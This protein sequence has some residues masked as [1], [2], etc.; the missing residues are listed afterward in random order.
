MKRMYLK[1]GFPLAL[2]LVAGVVSAQEMPRQM[3]IGAEPAVQP[4]VALEVSGLDAYEQMLLDADQLVRNG[5]PAEAYALLEPLEFEHAGEVRFDYLIGIAALDSGQPD[6]ATLAFER[7]LAVDSSFAGARL[8]MARAYYQ[9]GDLLRAKVEFDAVLK[10]DPPEAAR[11]TIEKY[12]AAIDAKLHAMDT[13]VT[14]YVEGTVGYDTNVNNATGQAQISVPALGNLVFTL[15]PSNQK[16]ADSYFGLNAGVSVAHPVN[17][18]VALYAGADIRDRSNSTL[19]SF[20]SVSLDGRAGG[21]FTLSKEDSLRVGLMAGQYTLNNLRNRDTLG[22]NGE[23]S[24]VFS[25]TNQMSL[26]FQQMAY[27][28]VDP[29]MRQEDF[30][31]GVLGAGWRHVRPDGKSVVFGSLFYGEERDNPAAGRT[32]GAKNFIGLKAGGQFALLDD[33]ELFLSAGAVDGKYSK[34]NL[35]FQV[36]RN[37]VLND[38]TA[39]VNWHLDKLWTVRPQLSWTHNQSNISLYSYDRIDGSVTVRRDFD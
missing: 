32:D 34:V 36:N 24:H 39:G 31:Q 8:D 25:P 11:S 37:D 9:L 12:L 21:V 28:F 27:R 35:L 1:G 2:L 6:K 22:V 4:Q 30:D 13:R 17:E 10:A 15:S 38:V 7:V 26:F 3:I 5:K 20:N 19:T 23:W 18:K 14:S 33:I 29:A 16:T